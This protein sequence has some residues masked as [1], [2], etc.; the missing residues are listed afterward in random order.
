MSKSAPR[1]GSLQIW[2][3]KRA[4]KFLP[5]VNFKHLDSPN[6]LLGFIGYKAAMASMLVKDSTP[7]S[8]TKNKNI[9]IP[10]TILELPPIKI[11]SARFYKNNQ[12]INEITLENPDK[13]TKKILK[14]PKSFKK[15]EDIKEEDYDDVRIL[16]Y[17]V[18]KRTSIKKKPDVA[19]IALSGDTKS[20]LEFIK[21]NAGKEISGLDILKD[22]KL[23]DIRGLTK[24]KGFQGSVKRFGLT[25]RD[26]KSEKGRRGPGSIGPVNPSRISFRVPMAGQMGMHTRVTYNKKVLQSGKITETDINPSQGFKHFGKLKTEYIILQGSVQGPSKRQVLLTPALRPTKYQEKKNYEPI[27]LV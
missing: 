14:N 2:P 18:V 8:L 9:T 10:V 13:E 22:L 15:I 27:K 26:H 24:G 3:R 19:E 12:L 6:P 7:D 1:K 17:S 4:K 20:K 21:N 25:L 11:Y 5:R 23:I 16:A